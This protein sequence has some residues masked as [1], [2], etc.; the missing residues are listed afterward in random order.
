LARVPFADR[1]VELAT[2]LDP[3]ADAFLDT[4]AVMASLDLVVS[5]DTAIAHLA[6]ALGRPVWTALS[7]SPE[8]RWL[9]ERSDSPWYPS[10]RLFRQSTDGD[11]VTVVTAIVQALAPLAAQRAG[12]L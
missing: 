12:N 4:A 1:I 2:D 8:W 3:G 10:M 5:C 6:G 11:W 7:R 9:L